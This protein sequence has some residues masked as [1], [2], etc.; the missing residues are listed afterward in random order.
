MRDLVIEVR[1]VDYDHWV[2]S[3]RN[4]HYVDFPEMLQTMIEV[5]S[6]SASYRY[7]IRNSK[8]DEIVWKAGYTPEEMI[9]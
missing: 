9:Q 7:R 4:G 2:P 6:L 1:Y 3:A 5:V 8:T